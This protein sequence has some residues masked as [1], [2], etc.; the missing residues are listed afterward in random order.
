MRLSI[1]PL[2]SYIGRNN[3]LNLKHRIGFDAGTRELENVLCW[4]IDNDFY[5]IDF[6]VD[7]GSNHLDLWDKNRIRNIRETCEKNG[8]YIGLHTLSAVNVAE[9]S[10]YVTA[11]VD[12]YMVGCVD[13]ANSLGCLWT[14]V[15]AGYHFTSDY[16]DRKK[17]AL[18]RLR[19]LS[20]YASKKG[21]K[22][23]LE[24][25][26]FEP[27]KSEVK[28][29]AYSI[30]ECKYFF[31]QISPELLGWAFTVNHSN[32]VPEGIDGFID[33]F[34]IDRVGEVRL[35]DN[36]GDYEVHMIPGEGNIDF[37]NMFKKI[38]SKGYRGHYSMA[39]GNSDEK[40]KSRLSLCN[41]F[42][43]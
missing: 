14:V 5:F 34:G 24:N 15:H 17:A 8:I 1:Y 11:G 12:D 25:L 18:D 10:P 37:K 23:L 42:D 39:Y 43:G 41:L 36:K 26:N 13:L 7:K 38:E 29:L 22:L 35:A 20:D 2:V 9:Y 3:I 6:N 27:K 30:E 19:R 28:Y 33:A 4:A 40:I 16:E 31:E 32:L 21:Q